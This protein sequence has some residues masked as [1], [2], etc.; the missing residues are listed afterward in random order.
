M[1]RSRVLVLVAA[2]A[3]L[4]WWILGYLPWLVSGLQ[5]SAGA[6]AMGSS[7]EGTS[8]LVMPLPFV[9]SALPELVACGIVGGV[10]AG[11]LPIAVTHVSR[12]LVVL[13]VWAVVVVTALIAAAITAQQ[14]RHAASGLFA[15]DS[16]V[17]AGLGA[18]FFAALALGLLAGSISV[19]WHGFTAIAAALV[20]GTMRTW[21]AAFVPPG[22]L[23]ASTI[24]WIAAVLVALVLGAGLVVSVHRSRTA[25][26]AWPVALAVLWLTGP[27]LTAV[28]YL[29][30][31][32][33]PSS[34]LPG[35][36]HEHLRAAGDVFGQAIGHTHPSFLAVAVALAAGAASV[37]HH[38]RRSGTAAEDPGSLQT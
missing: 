13:E 7:A 32:L 8:G 20:A 12:A 36:L 16:R 11:L 3:V 14:V 18:A 34:G 33:R 21:V 27:A 31:L 1:Q 19:H 15:A 5:V 9:A 28:N 38:H 25:L 6:G 22:R 23:D 37:V 30:A 35:T 4:G 10:V 24:S 29:T 2:L 26:L 17:L